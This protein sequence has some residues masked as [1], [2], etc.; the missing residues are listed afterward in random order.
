VRAQENNVFLKASGLDTVNG[1]TLSAS[2]PRIGRRQSHGRSIFPPLQLQAQRL[3]RHGASPLN[4]RGCV[5]AIADSICKLS[6]RMTAASPPQLRTQRST[7]TGWKASSSARTAIF[8][9]AICWESC[10]SFPEYNPH[11]WY[12]LNHNL[13]SSGRNGLRSCRA[14]A[15]PAR[16]LRSPKYFFP[17]AG[18]LNARRDKGSDSWA[19]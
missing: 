10:T 12:E 16:L 3:P 1:R 2:E 9:R 18:R 17:V 5:D 14:S 8:Q 7:S 4:R 19:K 15:F 6:R 13:C 11:P